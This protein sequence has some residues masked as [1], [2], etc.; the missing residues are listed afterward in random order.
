MMRRGLAVLL[1]AA[2]SYGQSAGG[3]YKNKKWGYKVRSLADWKSAAL[4]SSEVW[5][6]SKHLGPQRLESK[7]SKFY[8][9]GYPEMW[10]MGFPHGL[11]RGAKVEKK[12]ETTEVTIRNPYRGYKHLLT[13]NKHFL[14]GGYHFTKEEKDEVKGV[15]VTKYEIL[16]DKMVG[17]PY[18]VTAWVYHFKDADF[19]IQFKILDDYHKKHRAAFRAC[20]KSFKRIP[21]KGALPGTEATTGNSISVTDDDEKKLTPAQ[22]ASRRQGEFEKSLDIEIKALPDDW[23]VVRS[24]HY[25]CLANSSRKFAKE[26]VNHAE[27]I[28]GYLDKTFGQVGSDYV[29]PGMLRVFKTNGE[30]NAYAQG[31]SW[32]GVRQVYV[33][34]EAKKSGRKSWAMETVSDGVTGQWLSFKNRLLSDN[35]PWWFE[36]G[37]EQH[38]RFARVKGKHV[39]IKPDDWDRDQIKQI[40]KADK[41][42]PI[43]QLFEGG[44]KVQTYSMQCGSVISFML[45]K[46]N[47]GKIKDVIPRYM[48]NMIKAIEDAEA[49]YKKKRA[50]ANKAAIGRAVDKGMT[51]EEE[52]E[53]ETGEGDEDAGWEAFRKALKERSDAIRKNSFASTFGA[54]TDKDWE[55]LDRAWRRHAG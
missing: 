55:R 52:S 22:R 39:K 19:A 8:E 7:R 34:E 25:V 17:A 48:K 26:V 12:G 10:V 43:R 14:G 45:T 49:E 37:L 21:R 41:A 24:K 42:V 44:D 47:R 32:S 15:K 16:V 28:R 1:L 31:T 23:F 18:R 5:I 40:I 20:L 27:A 54:L 33:T 6:A 36:N 13:E 38:M 46:G 53:E 2:V 51:A 29:P 11:A 50:A 30:L 35:L 4:Q 9:S 3:Y